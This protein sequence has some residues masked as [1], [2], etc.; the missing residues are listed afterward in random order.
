MDHDEKLE[1]GRQLL[2][3][4]GA[5]ADLKAAVSLLQFLVA[6]QLKPDDPAS[7]IKAIRAMGDLVR[8]DSD[9]EMRQR[10]LDMIEAAQHLRKQG[11]HEA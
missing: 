6:A 9:D 10:A 3:L 5:I 11:K 8:N 7:G 4:D 2:K 1:I